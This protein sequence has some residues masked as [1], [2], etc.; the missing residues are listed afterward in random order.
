MPYADNHGVRIHYEVEGEGEPILLAHGFSSNLHAWY[1]MRYVDALKPNYQV[2]LVD[3]RGHGRSDRPHDPEAYRIETKVQDLVAIL[4][5]LDIHRAHYWGYS[6]G[7]VLGLGVATF[8]DDRF[9]SVVIGGAAP[10]PRDNSRFEQLAKLLENGIEPYLETIPIATRLSYKNNDAAAL[11]ATALASMSD[12]VMNL[13]APVAPCYVYNGGD[14]Q[15]AARAR[16]MS[17]KTP[18]SVHYVEIPGLDHGM[19]F[20]RSDLVLPLVLPFLSKATRGEIALA[21][22]L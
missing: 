18:A 5:D 9:K 13:D 2:I 20:Q 6:M 7:G 15:S 16:E 11:R 8:G 14:D 10:G 22:P 3:V 1:G 17:E 19:G 4:N 21:N 12:P